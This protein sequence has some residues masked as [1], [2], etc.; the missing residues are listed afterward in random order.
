MAD[1]TALL[2]DSKALVSKLPK[3]DLPPVALSL[4][5]IEAQSRRLVSRQPASSDADRGCVFS[6]L[7]SAL[8]FDV[9]SSVIFFLQKHTSMLLRFPAPSLT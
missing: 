1:L 3:A 9:K 7:P 4:D 6:I 5:Q 8:Q 2:N